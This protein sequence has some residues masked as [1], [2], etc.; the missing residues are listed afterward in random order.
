MYF[1]GCFIEEFGSKLLSGDEIDS[2]IFIFC[3]HLTADLILRLKHIFRLGIHLYGCWHTTRNTIS[4]D[5]TFYSILPSENFC[6]MNELPAISSGL[7]S[8]DYCIK[9]EKKK[10]SFTTAN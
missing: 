3:T 6:F 8:E 9:D 2:Y 1:I 4:M 10:K 5:A 7:P